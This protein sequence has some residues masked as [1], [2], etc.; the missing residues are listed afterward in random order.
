MGRAVRD[1]RSESCGSV[2]GTSLR[3]GERPRSMLM[4]WEGRL[5]APSDSRVSGWNGWLWRKPRVGGGEGCCCPPGAGGPPLPPGPEAGLCL[6]VA[7]VVRSDRIWF[8]TG[9]NT[10]SARLKMTAASVC[11]GLQHREER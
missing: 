4:S 7:A 6:T 9:P 11:I 8:S 2:D 5:L 10:A 3:L 1:P